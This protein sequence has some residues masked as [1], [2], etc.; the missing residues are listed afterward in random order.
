MSLLEDEIAELVA[1]G[2]A[3]ADLPFDLTLTRVVPGEPDPA[4]PWEPVADTVQEFECQ[5]FIDS[6]SDFWIS[7]GVVQAGDRKISIIAKTLS[8]VP[9]P[10]DQITARGETYT[11]VGDVKTDPAIALWECHC[12]G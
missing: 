4:K 12:R 1:D 5:G 6:Y 10:G 11:I 8:T 2:L 7:Q 9:M 3:A